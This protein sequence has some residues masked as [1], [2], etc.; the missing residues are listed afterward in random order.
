MAITYPIILPQ[1]P[2]PRSF[3]V[4][5]TSFVALTSSPWS[6]S[7]QAQLN[8]G[9][10]W[11][12]SIELPPMSED[13]AR[14]WS[15]I[16]GQLNGRFG[17][18]LFGDPKWKA[19]RGDWAGAPVVDTAGQTGQ[20]LQMRGFTAGAV[21]RAGDY[22]QIGSGAS[23]KL[24]KVTQDFTADGTGA[25]SIEIWPRIRTSP[26]DGDSLITVSPQGV[27]RLASSTIARS[28]EPFRHGYSFDMVEAL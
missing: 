16:M 2:A 18:F 26:V 25:A 19:P 12:F 23:A 17:T 9:Q 28:W 20:T 22:F 14:N 24:H 27:F 13:Q 15:G 1:K 11:A 21:G 10:I 5:E 7:Q 6:G 8:Q 4:Q 3:T